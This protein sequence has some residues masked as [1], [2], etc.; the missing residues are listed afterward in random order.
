MN[1]R[2]YNLIFSIV[3]VSFSSYSL[4]P[5]VLICSLFEFVLS[6]KVS[7]LK[8]ILSHT[9]FIKLLCCPLFFELKQHHCIEKSDQ[10]NKLG[11]TR[12]QKLARKVR[13]T[14]IMQKTQA[15]S[16]LR[17]RNF[18]EVLLYLKAKCGNLDLYSPSYQG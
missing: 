16:Q 4:H 14:K 17:F 8:K 3:R 9:R 18:S 11:R 13:M 10:T 1:L 5:S 6:Q 15:Y 7:I 2:P 12:Y